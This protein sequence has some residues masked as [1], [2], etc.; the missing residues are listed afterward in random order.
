MPFIDQE[1]SPGRLVFNLLVIVPVLCFL[2]YTGWRHV[3]VI[4]VGVWR[5]YLIA[6]PLLLLFSLSVAWGLSMSPTNSVGQNSDEN[7]FFVSLMS[8]GAIV[9][10]GAVLLLKKMRIATFGVPLVEL[11]R[12]LNSCKGH[13]VVDAKKIRRVNVPRG[14]VLGVLGGIIV[15]S[16]ALAP[17]LTGAH[18]MGRS[19]SRFAEG[20]SAR[21]LL[22]DQGEKI[23]SGSRGFATRR[24]QEKTD[25][26]FKILCGR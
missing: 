23:F 16:T 7:W 9:G 24:R 14:I 25:L 1:M 26:V 15:L 4:D 6:F 10:F 8:A 13:R 20:W 2:M 3:G 19:C 21:L 17:P 18:V 11:L 5:A 22:V 12:D